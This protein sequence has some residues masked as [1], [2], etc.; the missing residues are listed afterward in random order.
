[1]LL[2][3][4]STPET[5]EKQVQC[6]LYDMFDETEKLLNWLTQYEITEEQVP[7]FVLKYILKE[8]LYGYEETEQNIAVHMICSEFERR[9]NL[10][11]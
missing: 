8:Y 10:F 2:I 5:W 3:E 4:H 9:R 11:L 7:D 1:M 6:L